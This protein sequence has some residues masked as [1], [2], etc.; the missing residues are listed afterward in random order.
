MLVGLTGNIG[1]GKSTVLDIFSKLGA[2]TIDSD[3]I[4]GELY[5]RDDIKARV[6]AILG[7]EIIDGNGHLHKKKIANIIFNNNKLKGK[8][9]VLLHNY[10]FIEIESLHNRNPDRVVVAEIP[11]LFETGYNKKMDKV[12]MTTCPIE[13]IYKRLT[14]GYT[15]EEVE[16][17]LKS[18]SQSSD[19]E[20]R[21]DYLINTDRDIADIEEEV[22][23]IYNALTK[24]SS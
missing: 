15:K 20:T 18:Q 23:M 14:P 5:T 3:K 9:E 17:R 4:V 7:N 24:L 22:K 21:A 11:L 13:T 2:L 10:V 19:R 12:I 1:T 6:I 16:S 8:L